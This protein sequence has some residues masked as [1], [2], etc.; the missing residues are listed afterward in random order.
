LITGGQSV[1]NSQFDILITSKLFQFTSNYFS[2]L[3]N[4]FSLHQTILVYCNQFSL[5]SNQN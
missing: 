2:L 4:Y 1:D 3:V 5:L